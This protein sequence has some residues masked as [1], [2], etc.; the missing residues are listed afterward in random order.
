[1]V[2]SQPDLRKAIEEGR[3]SFSPVLEDTRWGE[4][5]VDLRLGFSFTAL[6]PLDGVKV[7]VAHGLKTLGVANF[8]QTKELKE[9]DKLGKAETCTVGPGEFVLAMT[10]ERVTVPR[11]MIARIEGRSTYAR[12]GL[13]MHQTAPWIQ[14]G[15]D[16]KIILEIMNNG[17]LQIELTPLKDRPCQLTFFT[18]SSPVPEGV[19]YGTRTTD[20]YQ[21][22][23]HPLKR[24]QNSLILLPCS[25]P[26]DAFRPANFSLLASSLTPSQNQARLSHAILPTPRNSS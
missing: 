2:L 18:L 3:L 13:S 12:V 21:G 24:K 7:S 9:K 16:G 15:W 14:P 1:M 8:W 20:V 23:T 22:R 25:R 17:P 6:Q 10:H 11:D 26:R 5:S 4:A 19:A